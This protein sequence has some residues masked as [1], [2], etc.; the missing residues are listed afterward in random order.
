MLN[1]TIVTITGADGNNRPLYVE[2]MKEITDDNTEQNTGVYK[3][4]VG[5]GLP[6]KAEQEKGMEDGE[7]FLG[8]IIF[9][10]EMDQWDFLGAYVT[11][12]E[13]DQLAAYILSHKP[14]TEV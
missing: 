8:D 2:P 9:T 11:R 13:L 4:Y 7:R 3:V 14:L 12:E 10:P 1:G 5:D 6:D